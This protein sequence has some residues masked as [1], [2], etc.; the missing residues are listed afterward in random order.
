MDV[1]IHVDDLLPSAHGQ[2]PLDERHD[3]RRPQQS[4]AHVAVAIAV[5]PGFFV[6]VILFRR[7]DL[8][9]EAPEIAHRARLELDR[10]QGAG[11]AGAKQRDR[12]GMQARFAHS[13]LH[14][15]SDVVHVGIAARL[16]RELFGNNH[17]HYLSNVCKPIIAQ[18]QGI[19]SLHRNITIEDVGKDGAVVVQRP[20]R[21]C[22][23]R[24]GVGGCRL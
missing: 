18:I 12:A 3:Q 14:G 17:L 2:P 8:V 5:V 19:A 11:A 6:S 21:R 7:G 10:R 23:W 13:L 22:D 16:E 9:K 24:S 20:D 1:K 15:V 4:R